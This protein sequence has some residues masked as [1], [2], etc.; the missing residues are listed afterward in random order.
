MLVTTNKPKR[1]EKKL[2]EPDIPKTVMI[3]YI[4]PRIP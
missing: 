2:P 3:L 4:S 1:E